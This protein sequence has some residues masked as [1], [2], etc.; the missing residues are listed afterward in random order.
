MLKVSERSGIQRFLPQHSKSNIQQ[1]STNI[2]LNEQKQEAI[3]LNS[4]TRQGC[5]L[6]PYLFN[7]ELEVLTGAIR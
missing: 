3:T 1:T 4:E 6:F 7:I 5:L 2:K